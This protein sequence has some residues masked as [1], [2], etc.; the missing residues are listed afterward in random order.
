M[1]ENKIERGELVAQSVKN[2]EK[3]HIRYWPA[4]VAAH[5]PHSNADDGLAVDK[6]AVYG[7]QEA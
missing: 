1:K 5:S 3:I 6:T 4:V 7:V 2:G